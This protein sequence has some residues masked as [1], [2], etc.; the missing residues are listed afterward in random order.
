M[1]VSLLQMHAVWFAYHLHSAL[2]QQSHLECS[3]CMP[4]DNGAGICLIN[5]LAV[6][7]LSNRLGMNLAYTIL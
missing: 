2:I 1:V 3:D 7:L 6:S 5:S 4:R